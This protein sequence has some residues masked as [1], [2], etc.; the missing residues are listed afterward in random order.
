M[1]EIYSR[2]IF[3]DSGAHTLYNVHVLKHKKRIGKNGL[4]LA[5]PPVMWSQGDFSY[6][7]LKEGSDFRA[8]C[9]GYAEFIKKMHKRA[10]GDKLIFANVDVIS[11]PDLTWDVQRYF[12]EEHG[13]YPV[14]IVHFGAEEKH[15][16]RYLEAG[17]Y[18]LLGVG[19]LGQGV[20]KHEYFGWGNRFFAHICPKWNDFRPVI[21]T[22]GFAMTSWKLICCWPWWSV[23]SATWVKLSAYGWLYIPRWLERENRFQ[24]DHPSW[25]VNFSHR[26]PSQKNIMKHYWQIRKHRPE[27]DVT[28]SVDKWLEK[29]GMDLGSVDDDGKVD[30][31]GVSSH[32]RARSIANL[33]YL[34]DLEESR[35]IWPYPLDPAVIKKANPHTGRG[36]LERAQESQSSRWSTVPGNSRFRIY[37]SGGGGLVDTPEVLIPDR[38][39]HVMLTYHNLATGQSSTVDR[40]EAYLERK[41]KQNESK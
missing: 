25:T 19:G 11:N 21:K 35:P 20:S 39:P 3:I 13:V 41:A 22:H 27:C 30:E 7:S 8:Y 2:T 1:K 37:F 14:P 32:H 31:F 28:V 15:V 10:G 34:K 33:T 4:E 6:Y 24:F 18:D 16:D 29:L 36:W 40:L 26:S 38:R 12:E 23:D 5:R 17:R 9:D